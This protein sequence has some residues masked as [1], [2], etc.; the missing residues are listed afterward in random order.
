MRRIDLERVQAAR[1]N[2]IRDINRQIVLNYVRE[3]APISRAEIARETA[4]QR[5]TISVIVE[6]LRADGLIE[7]VRA[8]ESTGGRPPELLRLRSAGA[9]AIGVDITTSN[10]TIAISDLS[11][12]ILGRQEFLT[13]PDPKKT[14]SQVIDCLQG[15]VKKSSKPIEGIGVSIPGWVNPTMGTVSY[16]PYFK[17]RNLSIANDISSATGL[18]V[19]VDNDANAAALAE[20][21]FGRPEV[22]KVRDFIM[23]LVHEGIGTGIVLD[24]QLYRG[25][26][27]VAGEFGHMI[28]GSEAPVICSCGN[29]NCWEAF[30]CERAAIAR[31][32]VSSSWIKGRRNISY[33]QL[34]QRALDGEEAARS[35]IMQT[36][37]Y[38]GIGILNLIVGLS[39]EA[40]VVTGTIVS[41]WPLIS[42]GLTEMVENNTSRGLTVVPVI[43]STLG[44][45]PSLLGALSLVLTNKFASVPSTQLSQIYSLAR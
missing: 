25:A 13:N 44:E 9:A 16:V 10:T 5:S 28:I 18:M 2:T 31:Y 34:V 15:M 37:Y 7:V 23:V 22:S 20:L 4:L 14:I 36:A 38:L 35:A 33:A 43:A 39:P 8:R 11:G 17:W 40:V 3:R 24:G 19:A 41:A 21:W 12:R 26:N 27:G 30:S 1:P 32:L 29:R 6:Q 45:Q 42:P